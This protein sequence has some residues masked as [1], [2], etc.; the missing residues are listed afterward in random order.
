M[1]P[2]ASIH[3]AET[4]GVHTTIQGLSEHVQ[5]QLTHIHNKLDL[6]KSSLEG[7][8]GNLQS[9][10]TMLTKQVNLLVEQVRQISQSLEDVIIPESN[11]SRRRYN[12]SS[13]SI[14]T[15]ESPEP[16]AFATPSRTSKESSLGNTALPIPVVAVDTVE[17]ADD[18]LAEAEQNVR[19]AEAAMTTLSSKLRKIGSF[20]VF[21]YAA[22][23]YLS[24][25]LFHYRVLDP[26]VSGVRYTCRFLREGSCL[27]T[28]V[29]YCCLPPGHHVLP[30]SQ[31]VSDISLGRRRR[32]GRR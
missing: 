17:Q 28:C 2:A 11:S 1:S 13:P 30:F 24:F 26:G 4:F 21:Q 18:S 23:T 9:S 32:R 25:L 10:M 12:L 6:V 16:I 22:H 8:M 5:Q 31:P 14:G 15:F 27:E 19:E 29:Y 3:S 7:D 20:L